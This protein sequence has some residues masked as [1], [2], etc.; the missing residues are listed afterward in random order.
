MR[1][2]ILQ[3]GTADQAQDQE[4]QREQ[5]LPVQP[6][7]QGVPQQLQPEEASDAAPSGTP[8]PPAQ[9]VQ[10]GQEAKGPKDQRGLRRRRQGGQ[11]RGGGDA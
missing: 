4:A 9:A 7:L 11:W 1:T 8:R 6:V 10:P 2:G 5:A 3:P